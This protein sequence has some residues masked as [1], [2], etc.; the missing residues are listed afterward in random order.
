MLTAY[1]IPV[2]R[3]RIAG[4][5]DEAAQLA[6]NRISG[7]PQAQF[8]T[9][10]HKTDV[11]GVELDLRDET[12][13]C[14]RRINGSSPVSARF[15]RRQFGGVTVQP[16][17]R[18]GGLRADSGI[19]HDPQFGPVLCSAQAVS[20]WKSFDDRA[21][22]LPPLDFHA[23]APNDGAD[24]NLQA[25]AAYEDA[26]RGSPGLEQIFVRFSQLVAEI[27]AHRRIRHQSAL[28]SPEDSRARR[29]L[30]LHPGPTSPRGIFRGPLSV[31]ILRYVESHEH[32]RRLVT[33]RPIRPEDEPKWCASTNR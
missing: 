21:L 14:A 30:V 9:I 32:A 24:E 6:A 12:M 4:T 19:E 29:P 15:V 28:A 2:A 23:G 1:A 27:A 16:M 8:R 22:A 17:V 26:R 18:D 7:R 5:E 20:S 10:T 13:P 33:I 31:L 11:G 25:L 3:D